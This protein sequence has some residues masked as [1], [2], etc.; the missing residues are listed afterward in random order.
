MMP[1][2]DKTI[3]LVEDE[4]I[5]AIAEQEIVRRFGYE[6]ITVNDGEEAIQTVV[7]NPDV[8]LILMDIDLGSGIDGTET[9]RRILEKKNIP[10]VFLTSHSER[11][12]VER[13]RG[14]TRY[15]YVI[16]NS[17]DFV[18]QSSIEMAFELFEANEKTGKSES[19]L[20]TLIRTIPDLIWLKDVD[21]VYLA[22]N[23]SFEQFFGATE[24]EIVGKTDYDFVSRELADFFREHDRK[25]M[26]AG[27]PSVNEEWIP[28]ASDG[29]KALLETIK[30]PV[31]GSNGQIA[32]V[33]GIGRDITERKQAEESAEEAALFLETLIDAIPFPVYYKD[34]DGNYLGFNK[35]YAEFF[36]KSKSE[37]LGS[38]VFQILPPELAEV[39][40]PKDDEL[41]RNPGFQKY[42]S[43][44]KDSRGQMHDVIF[45]KAS[46]N[47]AKG[48]LSGLIGVIVD[49]TGLK[50]TEEALRENQRMLATLISNLPGMVYRCGNDPDRTM[51]FVSEG[52]NALTGYTPDELVD[53]RRISFV[54][55]IHSDD[56]K[57]V[58]DAIQSGILVKRAFQIEYRIIRADGSVIQVWEQGRGIYSES[59]DLLSLEGFITDITERKT[60]QEILK[61]SEK[62]YRV[63]VETTG[64]GYVVLDMNGNVLDA[65]PEYIR[66]SGRRK[67]EE[68]IGRSVVEWTAEEE[69]EKN[70]QAVAA[71]IKDGFIRNLEVAYTDKSGNRTPVEINATLMEAGGIYQIF[72]LC[73]DITDRKKTEEEIKRKNEE[74]AATNEELTV[75]NE[76]FEAANEELIAANIELQKAD[77]ALQESE[78]KYRSL[79]ER[80]LVG[81]YIIQDDLFK[82]VNKRYCEMIGYEYDEISNKINPIEITHP[83]DREMAEENIRK[84]I[85]GEIDSIEYVLRTIR[86]DGK[87]VYM[88]VIGG[89]IIYQGRPAVMGT[90]IDITDPQKGEAD[91]LS[92]QW[93]FKGLDRIDV[94]LHGKTDL[95]QMMR[96]ILDEML[97]IFDCDRAW[98]L[99]PCDPEADSWSVPMERTRPGYSGAHKMGYEHPMDPHLA[100]DFQAIIAAN[101]PVTFGVG[102]DL[103]LNGDVPKQFY[104]QS[105]MSMALYPKADKPW[106]LGMHQCSYPRIWTQIEKNLFQEIGNRLTTVLTNLLKLQREKEGKAKT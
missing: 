46:F 52:C 48:E 88:R 28:F 54:D 21:G 7:S 39:Y 58:R 4:L 2:E 104:F 6:V 105:R 11:E 78:S 33:L 1:K 87:A 27:K 57:M 36:Q 83:E 85:S 30:T 61:K 91:R 35:A 10:I 80:S 38:N 74:L 59:G 103:P 22:C 12:M 86:K 72:S 50:R 73:R 18:L 47:N 41:F 15:G 13:V 68:I 49:I 81:V 45:H 102:S 106:L 20:K 77:K 84:R 67:L 62:R 90:V 44:A 64:T 42:E 79:V 92:A 24:E 43:L 75:A 16:K 71:C 56:R 65:N 94:A 9:A 26:E 8:D 14:I 66:L 34:I 99:Y 31:I 29:H 93:L 82:Y 25:A 89:R 70:A 55:L 51:E 63:L 32:G 3:L 37:I 69:K 19:H 100:L 96:N 40:S 95:D 53:S 101:G 76:E 60:I 97:S 98:L 23:R 5:I 17:G